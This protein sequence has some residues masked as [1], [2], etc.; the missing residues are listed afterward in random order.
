MKIARKAASIEAPHS[1]E[2]DGPA[3]TG[4][5]GKKIFELKDEREFRCK[6][7]KEDSLQDELDDDEEEGDHKVNSSANA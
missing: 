2:K 6:I 5:P 7:E 4:T 3:Q 1:D